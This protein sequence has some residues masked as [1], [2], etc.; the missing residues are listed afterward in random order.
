[1]FREQYKAWLAPVNATTPK[2]K[3]LSMKTFTLSNMGEIAVKGH[4]SGMK[5]KNTVK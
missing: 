5:H 1:M 4:A 2:L 3:G